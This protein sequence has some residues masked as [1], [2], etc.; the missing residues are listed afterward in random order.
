MIRAKMI[1][2]YM[3]YISFAMINDGHVNNVKTLNHFSAGQ[4]KRDP[5]SCLSTWGSRI[6]HSPG[7]EN[8]FGKSIAVPLHHWIGLRE[9]QQETMVFTMKYRVFRL[10]FSHH[11]IL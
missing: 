1:Q 4:Q 9:N 3:F 10:K 2:F 7:S 6:F 8:F 5:M 11:P